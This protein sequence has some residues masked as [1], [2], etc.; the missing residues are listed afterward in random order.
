MI[1]R[2]TFTSGLIALSVAPSIFIKKATAN[3]TAYDTLPIPPILENISDQKGKVK[4]KIAVEEGITEFIKG[5]KTSTLG[6]NGNLLGPTLRAKKG[7]EVEVT[8]INKLKEE[9]TV[10]WHGMLLPG[11]MDGGPHQRIA[12]GKEWTAKWVIS[13]PAATVW[14]HPHGIGTT[15]KQ[16]YWGLGGLF[17]LD[18]EVSTRLNIPSSYGINDIPLVI[19]DKRFT[20]NGEMVYLTNM[21]DIMFGMMGN[22]VLV[23][24]AIE[25]TKIVPAEMI[26]FRILN[27]SNARTYNFKFDNGMTFYQIATDGGFLEAPVKLST[28]RLSPGERAEILVDFSNYKT[29]DTVSLEDQGYKFLH[30]KVEQAKN[31]HYNLPD[32]LVALEKIPE[33]TATNER[34]FSLNGMGHMVNINGKK[35][36]INRIDEFV[37]IGSTEIWNITADMGM[38]GMMMGQTSR[39]SV[40]HN[41]H[42]H[43]TMF[44]IISRNGKTPPLNEQ[45]WKDTVALRNGER[46]RV[47]A[48]FQHK[49]LFMYHCHIL[50]HEDNGMMGQ[51]S[52]S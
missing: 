41:F 47:I 3:T 21:R 16:V 25:P 35:M 30:I 44:Q 4:Y 5:V 8:V 13:Q 48:K 37:K 36:N 40:I 34:Y 12:P 39:N 11:E 38:H 45:G 15:A 51:F 29:G 1:T 26:R 7:D 52:V 33:H 9:T 43:G 24:G 22:T 32:K 31:I 23:N 17:I 2:R 49:G 19:Q 50:E 27:G 6:Y 14:Y 18:D 28:L 20:D 10:H 46:V 42:A